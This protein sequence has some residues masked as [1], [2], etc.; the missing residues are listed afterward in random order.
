MHV[1]ILDVRT[2]PDRINSSLRGSELAA[3]NISTRR[4]SIVP[5]VKLFL[6]VPTQND[7]FFSSTQLCAGNRSHRPK[8]IPFPRIRFGARSVICQTCK[9]IGV[10]MENNPS[11]WLALYRGRSDY[12]RWNIFE[13][14][15]TEV[16]LPRSAV[17]LAQEKFY[18]NSLSISL[19]GDGDRK[20]LI[21]SRLFCC[22]F[23]NFIS[24]L[25][26]MAGAIRE[27]YNR[28]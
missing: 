6:H 17:F 1:L 23:G 25:S 14:S 22:V 11:W 5:S 8:I 18:G 7:D 16:P 24:N 20:L 26:Q 9:L 13:T 4:F 21:V 15:R 19:R 2:F 10:S 27:I 12:G 28:I 3:D